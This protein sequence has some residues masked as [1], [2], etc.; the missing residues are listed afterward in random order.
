MT[1]NIKALCK[2][3]HTRKPFPPIQSFR[4]CDENYGLVLSNENIIMSVNI[5]NAKYLSIHIKKQQN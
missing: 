1:T 5:G 2:P 3:V 4:E